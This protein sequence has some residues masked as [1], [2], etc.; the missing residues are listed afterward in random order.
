M[1]NRR[2]KR[3]SQEDI[4]LH[5]LRQVNLMLALSD[6]SWSWLAMTVG[7]FWY[8]DDLVF[9]SGAGIAFTACGLLLFVE[10]FGVLNYMTRK[11]FFGR[12]LRQIGSGKTT[13][14]TIMRDMRRLGWMVDLF[15]LPLL[16]LCC[17]Y[18]ADFLKT[19]M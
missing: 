13:Q 12:M 6:T 16:F 2:I 18:T 8:Y 10:V 3:T 4:L 5:S 17:V 9:L 15:W 7:L 19:A 14:K 1:G 11:L